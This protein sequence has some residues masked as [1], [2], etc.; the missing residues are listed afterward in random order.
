[1]PV[2]VAVGHWLPVCGHLQVKACELLKARSPS[3]AKLH[4]L[5]L[6]ISHAPQLPRPHPQRS[7]VKLQVP[8]LIVSHAPAGTRIQLGF[9]L[10]HAQAAVVPCLYL[11]FHGGLLPAARNRLHEPG[12]CSAQPLPCR[13]V[14]HQEEGERRWALEAVTASKGSCIAT[15]ARLC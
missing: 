15:N 8:P 7:P 9:E 13:P 4:F 11:S 5:P 10:H 3:P 12:G 14:S 6:I 1:M 2:C